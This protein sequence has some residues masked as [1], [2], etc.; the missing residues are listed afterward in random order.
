MGRLSYLVSTMA[1]DE[2]VMQEGP[3]VKCHDWPVMGIE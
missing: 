1:I 3:F 2:L